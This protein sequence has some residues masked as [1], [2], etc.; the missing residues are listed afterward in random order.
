M[1][2]CRCG[3][4]R[5]HADS[6]GVTVEGPSGPSRT[7][8]TSCRNNLMRKW[9]IY[10]VLACG[11]ACRG[12]CGMPETS[13]TR[14]HGR[15]QLARRGIRH[16]GSADADDVTY[17]ADHM[18]RIRR[19]WPSVVDV[20]TTQ[21]LSHEFLCTF[22]HS[23]RRSFSLLSNKQSLQETRLKALA[24]VGTADVAESGSGQQRVYF[25]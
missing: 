20:M 23:V 12:D 17:L 5:K 10:T 13:R 15:R 4:R 21:H 25:S 22:S 8:P 14:A 11:T 24:R 3:S 16:A 19:S 9:Q 6:A 1:A 7:T 2:H 18:A